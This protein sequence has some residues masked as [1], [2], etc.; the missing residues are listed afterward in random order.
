MSR[1]WIVYNRPSEASAS[2]AGVLLGLGL[3][4]H[5][6]VLAATDFYRY[7]S[8]V[9]RREGEREGGREGGGDREKKG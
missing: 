1:T 8:Y 4:G 7:L 9:V 2:H 6:R 5:M 3:L